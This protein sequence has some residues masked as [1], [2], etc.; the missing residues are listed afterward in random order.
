M[1][2]KAKNKKLPPFLGQKQGIVHL[3]AKNDDQKTQK[4]T[5]K[6]NYEQKNTKKGRDVNLFK[7]EAGELVDGEFFTH[8]FYMKN[9]CKKFQVIQ[10]AYSRICIK[11]VTKQHA[12]FHQD[13]QVII[14]ANKKV[15]SDNCH[16]EFK[17]VDEIK[18]LKSGKYLYTISKIT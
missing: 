15:M 7:T 9:W 17:I 14:K 11:I 3:K 12:D 13:Q 8:L 18:P 6:H 1:A 10:E 2:K 4:R 16:V 5:K